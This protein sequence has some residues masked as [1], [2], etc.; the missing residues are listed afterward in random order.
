[1]TLP[2]SLKEK[3]PSCH[4][5]NEEGKPIP[6]HLGQQLAWDSEQRTIAMLAGS[7]SGKA[8]SIDTMIPTPSGMKRMEDIQVGDIVYGRD[9]R[10]TKVTYTS[11]IFYNHECYE[12]TFDDDNV[13]I[14]DAD[15]L[16]V[17]RNHLQRKNDARRIKNRINRTTRPQ[18]EPRIT[19]ESIV[20]TTDMLNN[21]IVEDTWS[22]YSIDVSSPISGSLHRLPLHPY[23]LGAWLGDGHSNCAN[24]TCSDYDIEIIE[25]IKSL[26]YPIRQKITKD[27]TP[28]YKIGNVIHWRND[29]RQE[30]IGL[31]VL[32]NKHI[33]DIYLRAGIEDRKELLA[34]LLDTDGYCNDNGQAEFCS[35]KKELFY[36][37]VELI[38]SLG[39]KVRT[40]HKMSK[41]YGKECGVCYTA[42]FSSDESP[43]S[44]PRKSARHRPPTKQNTKRR[45]IIDIRK[46]ESVPTKCIAVDN[47]D[48]T[49]LVGE[50]FIPTHNTSFFPHWLNREIDLC[51]GGDH[52]AITA[53]YDLFKLKML[54]TMLEVFEGIYQRARFWN[55][56]RV[57]ELK[58]PE[59]DT[60][61]AR[62]SKDRM[63]GR[64]ILRSA[65]ALSGLESATAR[66][67]CLDEA[68][69]DRFTYN[70]YKA[71]RRR[72]T[73]S[74]GRMLITTT[75][76]NVGWL[77]NH[78]LDPAV[79]NAEVKIYHVGEAE[80]EHTVNEKRNISI[81]QFDSILNPRF[82]IEE[83]EEQ[84]QMLSDEEFQMMFR[85]R[86]ANLRFMI[87]NNF[88]YQ[89]MTCDPFP[90]HPD[91]KKYIGVDFGSANLAV[92]FFAEDPVSGK[93][94]AYREA[95]G[96][97]KAIKEH[98][99]DILAGETNIVRAVGGAASEDQWRKE[100]S[101]HGLYVEEPSIADVNLG[102][103][104]VYAQ[105]QLNNVIIFN[106]LHG[107]LDDIS[108]YRRK[109]DANGV[110]LNDIENKSD[111]HFADAMR[112]II[113]TIRPGTSLRAKVIRLS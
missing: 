65:D 7:Q 98:V 85:G 64:I 77:T 34:G 31:D 4:L 82:S 54:P 18:C 6:F 107:I 79:E 81:I 96:A 101:A 80:L 71:I 23:L 109:R 88:N 62:T 106:N 39:Y 21:T 108:R 3:W 100:F 47:L 84:R 5:H 38:C 58:D 61:W 105:F 60:F 35:V 73:L 112:Y 14:A 20:K 40:R 52:L 19:G 99:R 36:D 25:K 37:V 1:M 70:A 113:S 32:N 86:K 63:W 53:S 95:K 93:L 10:E 30:L 51:N 97:E 74:R 29:V 91:W 27:R 68:G 67:A 16:W 24:I 89:T 103:A 17:V 22:N 78:I 102:I 66:S 46:I 8:L 11:P 9:G 2:K 75:L 90:I 57:L 83:F 12:I 48:S 55:S 104:R 42:I 43:F 49:Y 41:I 45:Y 69:I 50:A 110:I 13:I 59:T 111:Y 28:T 56:D 72:L 94:F 76:Y 26:G 33:P 44:L 87:Y 92:L 15:H